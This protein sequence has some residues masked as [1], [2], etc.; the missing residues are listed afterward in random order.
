MLWDNLIIK[1]RVFEQ[2]GYFSKKLGSKIKILLA[3]ISLVKLDL[4]EFL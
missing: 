1:S 2:T 3:T 4:N